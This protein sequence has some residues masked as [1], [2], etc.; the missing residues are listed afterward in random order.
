MLAL[1]KKTEYAMIALTYLA[2]RPGRTISARE[3]AA[4]YNMPGAL[5]MN[6]LKTL[7]HAGLVDSTRGTKGGYRV[8]ADLAA[9]SLHELIAVLEGPVQ[10][11]E[12]A[13]TPDGIREECPEGQGCKISG[14]C[15]IQGAVRTLHGRFVGLLQDVKLADLLQV[16]APKA[17]AALPAPAASV[18]A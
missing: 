10:L 18:P 13:S 2:E 5:V 12:C 17:E 7:H 16:V 3:I 4:A 14:T 1:T 9:V 8:R 6:I 15:P 11:A